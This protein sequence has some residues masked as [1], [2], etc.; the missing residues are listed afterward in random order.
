MNTHAHA[1]GWPF[2][3]PGVVAFTLAV[4]WPALRVVLRPERRRTT[5]RSLAAST[6][7]ALALAVPLGWAQPFGGLDPHTWAMARFELL[8]GAGPALLAYAVH[9]TEAVVPPSPRP[10][11]TRAGAGALVWTA[12]AYAW[13]LPPL[14]ALDGAGGQAVRDLTWIVAGLLLWL[15]ALAPGAPYRGPLVAAHLAAVPLGLAMLLTG[16]PGAGLLMLAADA[17]MAAC[18]ARGR[19]ALPLFRALTPP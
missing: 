9:A 6:A 8:A 17:V 5:W 19:F 11:R 3:I 10:R 14:D 16:R 13:Q 12:A 4:S 18:T 7:G 1:S 15:P 2:A